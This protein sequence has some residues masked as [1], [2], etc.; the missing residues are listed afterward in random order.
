MK[1]SHTLDPNKFPDEPVEFSTHNDARKAAQLCS[2]AQEEAYKAGLLRAAEVAEEE[3]MKR[4][5]NGTSLVV[6]QEIRR[7]ASK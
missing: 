2:K 7:E 3:E 6:A 4:R 5:S 1:F